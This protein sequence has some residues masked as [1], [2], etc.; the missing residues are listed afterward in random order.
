MATSES[1]FAIASAAGC[2]SLQWK[3]ADTA[4]SM[5]RLAPLVLAISTARSTAALSPETT[6]CP[7]PLSLAAWQIW[8]WAARAATT[9][10][11]GLVVEPEQGGHGAHA[12]RHRLLHRMATGAQQASGIAR[13]SDRCRPRRARNTR[14]A[15]G[16]RRSAASRPTDKPASVSSTRKVA[17]ETAISA[18][19]V[20]SVSCSL[21]AGP[22]QMVWVSFSP[23]AA[24]TSSN[25]VLA[26]GK[27]SASAL[28]I[29]TAWEPCPGKVNAAVI[30]AP[31]N[32]QSG[33]SWAVRHRPCPSCQA[34]RPFWAKSSTFSG[35]FSLPF[36]AKSV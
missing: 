3:G 8:P 22:S 30:G 26:A 11:C 14:R 28:P 20:F 12:D 25:T 7:P 6:T 36:R 33:P 18:G 13:A 4:S 2:I 29:P 24:S 27:A 31:P 5:A 10:R 34:K 23:S 15:N 17:I 21:S 1:A 35:L 32:V 9:P 16:R 19:W